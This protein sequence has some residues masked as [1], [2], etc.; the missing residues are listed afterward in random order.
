MLPV[1][2]GGSYAHWGGR[3]SG[4][5]VG[6]GQAA[7]TVAM[8]GPLYLPMCFS[9]QTPHPGVISVSSS[10]HSR[11]R[12]CSFNTLPFP[13]LGFELTTSLDRY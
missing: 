7:D 10:I 6:H 12:L 11:G 3:K 1:G 2:R 4:L 8:K 5:D 9:E 13:L